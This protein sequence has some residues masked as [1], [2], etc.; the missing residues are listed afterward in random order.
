MSTELAI[1]LVSLFVVLLGLAAITRFV[2][3]DSRPWKDGYR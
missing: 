3:V 1:A 2:W